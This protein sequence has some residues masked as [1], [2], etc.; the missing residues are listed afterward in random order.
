MTPSPETVRPTDMLSQA[1]EKMRRGR[2]RR[3]PVVDD[4][5]KLLGMLTDGDLRQHVGY[6]GSTRVTAAM[7]EK[8]VTISPEATIG[9]AAELMRWH[10]IGGLPVVDGDGRLVGIITESDLLLALVE[11]KLAEK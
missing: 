2:F 5:G 7:V 6:L 3:V 10:K 1:D 4:S 9:A 11:S 8:P